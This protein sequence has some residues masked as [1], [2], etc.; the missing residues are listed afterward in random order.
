MKP[1]KKMVNQIVGK[2][3]KF[4]EIS[5]HLFQ[6]KLSLYRIILNKNAFTH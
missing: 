6:N 1:M 2:K 4:L 5:V 3:P